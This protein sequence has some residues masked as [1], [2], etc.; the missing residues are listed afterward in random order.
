MKLK[1]ETII[2]APPEVDMARFKLMVETD[3]AGDP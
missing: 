3:R 1:F 2:D